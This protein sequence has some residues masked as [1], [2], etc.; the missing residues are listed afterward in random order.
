MGNALEL[1]LRRVMKK[2]RK[3]APDAVAESRPEVIN[4]VCRYDLCM[5]TGRRK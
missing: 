1:R 2:N 5:M 4:F 3:A